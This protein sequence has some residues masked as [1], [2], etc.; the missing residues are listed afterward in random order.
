[1]ELAFSIQTTAQIRLKPTISDSW[2]NAKGTR[3]L[4]FLV[5]SPTVAGNRVFE[6]QG[7]SHKFNPTNKKAFQRTR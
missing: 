2:K 6:M 4:N 3:P 7:E 1:L 5:T